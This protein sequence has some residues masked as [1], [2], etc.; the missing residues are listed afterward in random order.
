MSRAA[1]AAAA[2]GAPPAPRGRITDHSVLAMALFVFTEVMLFAAFISGFII[3]QRVV[4]AGQWPPPGQPR[5]PFESTML[6][7]AA[8]LASGVA[9]YFTRRAMR[10]K[11]PAA[12]LGPLGLTIALGALFL[13]F[14]GTE[15]LALI[16]HGLTL[17][18]SQIGSF[19]YLIVG[20]HAL[21]AV[22]ALAGLVYCWLRLRAGRLKPSV[23][24][25]VQLFWYFVVLMW[26]VIYLEVY[27]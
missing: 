24:G 6:N 14:Q 23:F 11:G 7:T 15:W 13:G 19:F 27:R 9:L 5:L 10:S 8:L 20:A 21:H 4:P 18:S 17:T 2:G 26:P 16:R 12:G 3:V 22:V 1:L 25:G